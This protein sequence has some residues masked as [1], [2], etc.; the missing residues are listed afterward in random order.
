MDLTPGGLDLNRGEWR[1]D[2]TPRDI[3]GLRS[4]ISLGTRVE[5][6]A[7]LRYQAEILRQPDWVTGESLDGFTELDV[8]VGWHANDHWDL[9]LVGQNLL[10]DDHVEF[11][12]AGQRGALER[13]A[14]LK[15]TWRN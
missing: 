15:A 8:H 11:G 2:S 7:Q 4:L 6:D 10:H 9:A 14:Y 12:P 1:E 13:A 3:A 5:I